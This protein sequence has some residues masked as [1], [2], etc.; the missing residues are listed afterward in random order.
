VKKSLAEVQPGAT[1]RTWH[2]D[3]R[4]GTWTHGEVRSVAPKTIV[5]IW[6]SGLRQRI[7][8]ERHGHLVE[9]VATW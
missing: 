2:D 7:H 4:G 9:P 5:V 8:K 1:V 3:G 6:E